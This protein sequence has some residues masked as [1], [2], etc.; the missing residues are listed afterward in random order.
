MH[1]LF[2]SCN[3]L[4]IRTK[5]T[6]MEQ[7]EGYPRVDLCMLRLWLVS[8]RW[9][10]SHP[11][12]ISITRFCFFFQHQ[13]TYFSS[14][15]ASPEMKKKRKTKT[16]AAFLNEILIISTN[17]LNVLLNMTMTY[18]C[19]FFSYSFRVSCWRNEL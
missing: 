4:D 16:V 1:K 3:L 9:L 17:A 19:I 2:K 5:S 10:P 13:F 11:K 14:A 12:S 18:N 15:S 8:I 7:N 6:A